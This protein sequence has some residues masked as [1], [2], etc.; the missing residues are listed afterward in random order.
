[1]ITD[2]LSG[3]DSIYD[4]WTEHEL[5]KSIEWNGRSLVL[6]EGDFKLQE[7]LSDYFLKAPQHY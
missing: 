5:S 1:M 2:D 3:I 7:N 4:R 6:I